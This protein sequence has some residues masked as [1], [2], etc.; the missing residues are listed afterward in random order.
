MHRT[1][2]RPRALLLGALALALLLSGGPA[3][4]HIPGT[5]G[6]ALTV[7]IG[8]TVPLQMTTKKA[9]SL[10]KNSKEDV[11]GVKTVPGDPTRVLLTGQ[12]AG[13]THVE[14]TDVDGK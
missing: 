8:G 12:T 11:L 14:L 1:L 3:P 13:I 2:F 7:P 9:I 6:S 5:S 4:A 10:V